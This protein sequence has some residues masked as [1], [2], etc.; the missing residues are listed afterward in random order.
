MEKNTKETK[1]I[2]INEGKEK[3]NTRN[4]TTPRPNTP[5][6]PQPHTKKG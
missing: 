5:P 3:G 6:A 4:I 1:P 2:K